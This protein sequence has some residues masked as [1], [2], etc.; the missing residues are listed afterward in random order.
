MVTFVQATYVLATVV[1]ISNISAITDQI[2]TNSLGAL[3][4]HFFDQTSFDQKILWTKIFWDKH[5]FTLI[6][7][8]TRFFLTYDLLYPKFSGPN[9]FGSRIFLNLHFF[10]K[11]F[12]DLNFVQTRFFDPELK[13]LHP[14]P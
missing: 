3:R 8:W 12:F 10:D 13:P 14:S 4:P 2:L 11:F 6:Y 9:I 1:H 7:C 5:F